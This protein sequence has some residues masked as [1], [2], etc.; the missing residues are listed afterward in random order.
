MKRAAYIVPFLSGILTVASGFF[1]AAVAADWVGRVHVGIGILFVLMI[2]GHV[3]NSVR[4]S[5]R[6]VRTSER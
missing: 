4:K 6:A 5:P 2:A 1:S 3:R